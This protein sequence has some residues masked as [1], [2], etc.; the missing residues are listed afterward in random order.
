ML[1]KHGRAQRW[2]LK[3]YAYL[4]L[5]ICFGAGFSIELKP[6]CG[7]SVAVIVTRQRAPKFSD[8]A[9]RAH[10]LRANIHG[11]AR[12][13]VSV[14]ERARELVLCASEEVAPRDLSCQKKFQ[15]FGKASLALAVAAPY[16]GHGV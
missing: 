7:C 9:I 12:G 10:E 8:F 11:Y 13:Y 14:A 4:M 3:L 6:A 2:V 5:Y 15:C 1:R 16:C